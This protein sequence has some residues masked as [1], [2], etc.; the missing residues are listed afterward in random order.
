MKKQFRKRKNKSF[1]Q[2]KDGDETMPIGKLIRKH[3]IIDPI[4][5][6]KAK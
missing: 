1:C 5:K 6:N 3:E 4:D 2:K